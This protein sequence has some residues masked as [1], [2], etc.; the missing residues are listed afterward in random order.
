MFPLEHGMH[1][2]EQ[3]LFCTCMHGVQPEQVKGHH[4]ALSTRSES[5]LTWA[6]SV[7][8]VLALLAWWPD[9]LHYIIVCTARFTDDV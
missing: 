5:T 8:K 6:V 9:M 7:M 4:E 1:R 3:L 2:A